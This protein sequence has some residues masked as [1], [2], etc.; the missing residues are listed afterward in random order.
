MYSVLAKI[1]F[2]R[3]ESCY[4]VKGD[5]RSYNVGLK[6]LIRFTW[7]PVNGIPQLPKVHV[8]SVDI[9]DVC[10]YHCIQSS[11][12][13]TLRNNIQYNRDQLVCTRS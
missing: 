1:F 9:G 10:N 12:I 13:F 7:D 5:V 4:D 11:I 6:A 8:L 2:L 3:F